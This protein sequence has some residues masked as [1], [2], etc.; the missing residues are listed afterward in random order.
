MRRVSSR[1]PTMRFEV[2]GL[3]AEWR[4][5][6]T[7]EEYRLLSQGGTEDHQNSPV[8]DRPATEPGVYRCR[9]RD[10]L[11]YA[12][13]EKRVLEKKQ[14]L[15]KDW[16]FFRHSD[17][18]AVLT[19]T[20]PM[21]AL[22]GDVVT[23]MEVQRRRCGSHLGYLVYRRGEITHGVNGA[24]VALQP[25]WRRCGARQTRPTPSTPHARLVST[26]AWPSRVRWTGHLSAISS[27]L[28]RVAWSKSPVSEIVR[29]NKS[30]R[31][32][33]ISQLSQSAA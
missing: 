31:P 12:S 27:S 11:L 15:E 8:W 22:F 18:N 17:P 7:A 4:T 2:T 24:A 19:G 6:L 10:Q 3:E 29:R 9:G 23:L 20:D 30:I 26:A 21:K 14:V 32:C 16:G 13:E 1:E 5:R 33:L 25:A 28:A